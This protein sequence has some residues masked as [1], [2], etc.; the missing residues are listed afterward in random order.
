MDTIFEINQQYQQTNSAVLTVLHQHKSLLQT[1]SIIAVHIAINRYQFG[2]CSIVT[3]HIIWYNTQYGNV[4]YIILAIYN[5]SYQIAYNILFT[6]NTAVY[7]SPRFLYIT[8][9]GGAIIGNI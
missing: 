3:N 7:C 1:D 6:I 4:Q 2:N 5:I 8:I 9:L